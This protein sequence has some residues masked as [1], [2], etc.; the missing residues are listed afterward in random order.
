MLQSVSP[1]D[2]FPQ[3]LAAG[4]V[5]SVRKCYVCGSPDHMQRDCPQFKKSVNY[6]KTGF[7]KRLEGARPYTPRN[8]DKFSRP[9]NPTASKNTK[10]TYKRVPPRDQAHAATLNSILDMDQD[11]EEEQEEEVSYFANSACSSSSSSSE[12]RD[13]FAMFD[14][15]A[16][17]D[18]V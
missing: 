2:S 3:V 10:G 16:Y 4:T 13:F 9:P 17:G 1:P 14:D 15:V 11:E 7:Q 8:G 12:S 5:P 6:M 18:S